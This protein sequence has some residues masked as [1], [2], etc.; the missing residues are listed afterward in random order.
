M[1]KLYVRGACG[2]IIVTDVK[3]ES[4][5]QSSLKWKKMIEEACD[6]KNG[7][8]IPMILAQNKVDELKGVG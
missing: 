7:K 6:W 4:T 2:A 8:P 5:L 1:S 3:Q